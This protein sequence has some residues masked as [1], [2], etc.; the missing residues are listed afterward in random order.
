MSRFR[1]MRSLQKFASV[2]SSVH[3]HFNHQ[4]NIDSR[5][6]FKLL[7]DAALLEWRELLAA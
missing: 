1:R 2:H 6:R 7:C 5:A 3:N 4:R